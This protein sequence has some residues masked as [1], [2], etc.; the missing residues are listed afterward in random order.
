[1]DAFYIE[2]RAIKQFHQLYID[3]CKM[4]K[5]AEFRRQH[6]ASKIEKSYKQNIDLSEKDF[7]LDPQQ[8][9]LET[10]LNNSSNKSNFGSW[11]LS[12]Q[13]LINYG[14]LLVLLSDRYIAY[15]LCLFSIGVR[16]GFFDKRLCPFIIQTC[17]IY[18]IVCSI[19]S[20]VCS[21]CS[22]WN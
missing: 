8:I 17:H 21:V 5:A 10:K 3:T 7:E 15:Y 9:K 6:L 14:T 16:L 13:A 12:G 2:F 19:C 20:I 11:M 1:M 18:M 22:I 4:G